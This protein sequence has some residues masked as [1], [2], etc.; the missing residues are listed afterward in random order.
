M[1]IMIFSLSSHFSRFL[2]AFVTVLFEASCLHFHISPSP[3]KNSTQKALGGSFNK[4]RTKPGS[5]QNSVIH[6]F[7]AT[8]QPAKNLGL[9]VQVGGYLSGA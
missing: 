5:V 7:L 6:S 1:F 2:F 4:H 3:K 9:I 8:A